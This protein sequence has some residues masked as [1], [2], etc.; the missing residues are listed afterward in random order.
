M[1]P[2]P[3]PVLEAVARAGGSIERTLLVGDTSADNGAA[4]AARIPVVLVDYG[5]SHMP[6][7]ALTYGIIVDNP[8]SLRAAVMGF[9][10]APK[11]VSHTDLPRYWAA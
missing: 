6:I 1:K 3:R 8:V 9:V 5:Y 7:S 2:H 4:I 10:G 11:E